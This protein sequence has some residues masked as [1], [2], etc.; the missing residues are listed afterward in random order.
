MIMPVEMPFGQNTFAT[1]IARASFLE[2][3]ESLTTVCQETL[4]QAQAL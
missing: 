2:S 3:F 4:I 1:V